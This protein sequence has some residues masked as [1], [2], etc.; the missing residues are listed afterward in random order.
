[1]KKIPKILTWAFIIWLSYTWVNY[2]SLTMYH[3]QLL[4]V[5]ERND[6]EKKK[7]IAEN[8]ASEEEVKSMLKENELQPTVRRLIEK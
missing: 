8:I 7:E 5:I 1:M 6:K 3:H 4:G 2:L